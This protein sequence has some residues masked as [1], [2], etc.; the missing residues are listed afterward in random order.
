MKEKKVNKEDYSKYLEIPII[1]E[2]ENW[3]EDLIHTTKGKRIL[4]PVLIK[5][6]FWGLKV[7]LQDPNTKS[8]YRIEINDYPLGVPLNIK[9]KRTGK[10]QK[11]WF[12]GSWES[13]LS[14]ESNSSNFTVYKLFEDLDSFNTSFI[15]EKKQY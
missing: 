15:Y 7:Y 14:N 11:F 8:K 3:L 2:D 1:G 9:V 12:E 13:Q 10:I 4:L 5:H 6:N